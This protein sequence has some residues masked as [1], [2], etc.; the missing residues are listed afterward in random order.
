ME[1][2]DRFDRERA[3]GPGFAQIDDRQHFQLVSNA[4]QMRGFYDFE[5]ATEIWF[6]PAVDYLLL[7]LQIRNW[8]GTATSGDMSITYD[9]HVLGQETLHFQSETANRPLVLEKCWKT[10]LNHSFGDG[11]STGADTLWWAPALGVVQTFSSS[12]ET[13]DE[14]VRVYWSRDRLL[15]IDPFGD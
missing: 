11:I 14:G 6:T 2:D 4:L 5:Q 15:A 12:T 3:Y 10:V 13:S 7:P 9:G 1:I 8:S